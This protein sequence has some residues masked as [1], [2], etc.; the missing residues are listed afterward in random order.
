MQPPDEILGPVTVEQWVPG[1]NGLARWQGKATFLPDTVPGDEVRFR[2]TDDKGRHQF[3]EVTEVLTPSQHRQPSPCPHFPG[4]GGCQWLEGETSLQEAT[5]Q[6]IV[7][8]AFA[9]AQRQAAK[10]DLTLGECSAEP[11]VTLAQRNYRMRAVL[12]G[13][14]IDGKWRLGFYRRGS[15][16][17]VSI[18]DCQVLAPELMAAR[19]AL[20]ASPLIQK[21]QPRLAHLLGGYRD[22]HT[23]QAAD[24]GGAVVDVWL[25]E[26][27]KRGR[28]LTWSEPSGVQELQH[29]ATRY[30]LVG[31]ANVAIRVDAFLQAH[32]DAPTF[33]Y[34]FIQHWTEYNRLQFILDIYGGVGLYGLA[35]RNAGVP[36]IA[37]CDTSE[38]SITCARSI[39]AES[40]RYERM[41]A[42]GFLRSKA[43]RHADGIIVNPP[44]VGLSKPVVEGLSHHQAPSMLYVSCNP[45]TL[46]RDVVRLA[47]GGWRVE[48]VQPVDLFP[49]THHVETIVGL[50]R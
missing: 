45:Q 30:R 47:E 13:A 14:C 4:C 40:W 29:P 49:E 8:D 25:P 11:I 34:D 18:D 21:A 38:A 35:A 31:E 5:K 7:E 3:G 43:N 19:V 48:S 28:F 17:L 41:D 16:D 32:R 37:G 22:R 20:E 23:A 12:H 9:N 24:P 1:G 33:L 46:G 26:R 36:Q 15:R 44:R 2:V 27:N 6:R 42:E 50:A 39:E 10:R